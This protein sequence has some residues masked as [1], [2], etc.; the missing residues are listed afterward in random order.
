MTSRERERA[1]FDF[2]VAEECQVY[3]ECRAYT[4]IYGRHVIEIEYDDNGI[5]AFRRACNLRG[6]AISV[7]FRDR[8]LR[9]P[10]HRQYEYAA[11]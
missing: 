2:A 1:G 11:C 7:V 9:R 10:S 4:S 6:D 3:S 8:Q 5:R